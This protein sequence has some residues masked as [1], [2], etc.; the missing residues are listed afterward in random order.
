MKGTA[1][2]KRY[3]THPT[4][5]HASGPAKLD[6]R[7]GELS[8]GAREGCIVRPYERVTV[9]TYSTTPGHPMLLEDQFS[10]ANAELKVLPLPLP[11]P[12]LPY[13]ESWFHTLREKLL[14]LRGVIPKI[15]TP[16]LLSL[17]NSDVI[18]MDGC[19][20]ARLVDLVGR[21]GIRALYGAENSHWPPA[22]PTE[23]DEDAKAP[24]EGYK[25]LN[26][27][28]LFAETSFLEKVFKKLGP[29]EVWTHPLAEDQ[30]FHKIAYASSPGEAVLDHRA[31]VFFNLNWAFDDLEVKQ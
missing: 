28:C 24:A 14:A 3:G 27:G 5:L 10:L 15:A 25:H 4:I 8:K 1:Y 12:E 7:W 26:A 21:A 30:W 6:P 18:V 23:R 16:Y 9:V 19:S 11:P 13:P 20:L 22:C 2:N 29:E 31:E 17:D